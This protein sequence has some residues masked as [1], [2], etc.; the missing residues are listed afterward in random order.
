MYQNRH[1]KTPFVSLN[2]IFL[3]FICCGLFLNKLEA[4]NFRFQQIGIEDGLPSNKVFMTKED[5]DGFIWIVTETGVCRY[6][7]VNLKSY[8]L[9]KIEDIRKRTFV[10]LYL[11]IDSKGKIW[12]IS[13]NGLLFKYDS[14]LDDFVYQDQVQ[15]D[16]RSNIYVGDF[17][18]THNDQFLLGSYNGLYR[19]DPETSETLKIDSISSTV[20]AIVK[21]KSNEYYIGSREGVFVIDPELKP[22]FNL[23]SKEKNGSW[24]QGD[25][26]IESLYLQ[27]SDKKLWIGT[28]NSG[29]FSYDIVHYEL[30][31]ASPISEQIDAPIRSITDFGGGK[32][33]IGTDG[34][35]LFLYDSFHSEILN[36][37]VYQEDEDHSLSSNAIYDIQMNS[38]GVIFISTYRGGLNIYNP[39]RQNF[40]SIRHIRGETSSLK[41]DVVLSIIEIQPGVVS[42]GTD[43]GLSIWNKQTDVWNHISL[44]PHANMNRSAVVLSQAQDSNENIWVASFIYSLSRV[45]FGGHR[46]S[47]KQEHQVIPTSS[48]VKKIFYHPHGEMI[49]GTIN[50]GLYSFLPSGKIKQYALQEP[51]D[52]EIFSDSKAIIAN[53]DGIYMLD[54]EHDEIQLMNDGVLSDS[55]S[56]KVIVSLLV[57]QNRVLWIGTLDN[58]VLKYNPNDETIRSFRTKDGLAS[59][60]IYDLVSDQSGHLWVATALGLS[61][62]NEKQILNFYE[63]DGL[64][65]TDF[66]RNAAMRDADGMLYFGT[67]RGVITFDPKSI[68]PSEINKKLVFTDFYLNHERIISGENSI[69]ENPLNETS[70]IT[71]LYNQNSFSIGF[72]NIDFVHPEQGEYSWKLEGFDDE[73]I[74]DDG[75]DRAVYTNLNPAEYVFRLQLSDQLGNLIA[76]EH[77]INIKIEKPIWKTTLAYFVYLLFIL[78]LISILLYSNRLRIESKNAAERLHFLIEMAH[79]IKTPLT[80]IRAPIVDL[81]NNT[82]TDLQAKESL[83]VALRSADKLHN[84]MMQFL[85]FKRVSIRKNRLEISSVDLIDLINSK[86]FA[87]R[88]LADKKNINLSFDNTFDQFIIKSDQQILDK[89]VSNLISNAIKYTRENGWVKLSL[90]RKDKKWILSVMDNGIGIPKEDQKKIFS[91]F[92]RTDGARDSGITG[93]GVGLVLASDLART[94]GGSIKL[95]NS[96]SKGSEFQVI[97]PITQIVDA[98]QFV[99]EKEYESNENQRIE[100]EV[101]S[102]SKIKILMVEDDNALLE[103]QKHKFEQKYKIFT[104]SNGEDALRIAQANLPDLI[105]SDV[106]MPKMNGRQLCMNIKS[107]VTTSHIPFILLTGLESK[108]NIQLGFESGADDYII[109]PFDFDMLSSKVDNLLQTRAAF[110]DKFVSSEDEFQYQDISNELDQQFLDDITRMVEENISDPELSVN[111]LCQ[112]MGMSRTSFYHKLKA[113]VDLSPAEFIRT[114]RLKRAR[115]LLLNPAN[116]ISEVAYSAG[117]SDAKYFSTIFKKYYNQSPSA[118]VAEKRGVHESEI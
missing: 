53:R 94:L 25:Q 9:E 105:I 26:K 35:G 44:D 39:Q 2:R 58:G 11:D 50:S 52:M 42:F 67:N 55:L 10:A 3:I 43:K 14:G 8:S 22:L 95:D 78:L 76:P 62:I 104:A 93:S 68:R 86:I 73:W 20:T 34:G 6:D 51:I 74:S 54:L 83:G 103:Y 113:L 28:E 13:N 108:E 81:L 79:E 80:L 47:L 112:A 23:K 100:E 45:S 37:L 30:V 102:D 77:Q 15:P 19:Y 41:N 66:N 72:T 59:N 115:K 16:N 29:L 107:N 109:K 114:I 106:M 97:M 101:L 49:I 4:Q 70:E 118:F 7:G 27:E 12:L 31:H 1:H 64:I 69:L 65:S 17:K 88:V 84:Q 32:L 75:I 18:I 98:D 91:L 89:I 96:S 60:I 48:K 99:R 57:D 46:Y 38:Q 87:F 92:Y 82:K 71:L 36:Q 33:M 85:D 63:S 40:S 21:T 24:F 61:K 90:I 56:N 116:N 111:Y 110:R 5:K 117:F